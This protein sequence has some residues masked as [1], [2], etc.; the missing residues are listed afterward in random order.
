MTDRSK[1]RCCV[2][3]GAGSGLGRAMTLG[4][5][6]TGATVIAADVDEAG[7]DATVQQ[8]KTHPGRV[9]AHR[10]D[11]TQQSECKALIDKTVSSLGRIDVLV[12]CAGL[13]MAIFSREFLTKLVRFWEV[14]PDKWQRLYDVNVRAPFLLAHDAAPHMMRQGWGRIVNI[15]TSF[16]T[17]MREGN[18]PYGQAKAA[19]EASSA[20]WSQELEGTGV[21]C[22]VLLPG[23]A[24]DTPMIPEDAPVDRSKLVPAAAMVAPLLYL[25]SDRSDGVTGIRILAARWRADDSDEANLKQA[26][27]PIGWPLLGAE[28]GAPTR[29]SVA[30]R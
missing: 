13:N 28:S 5:A 29:G 16:S 30:S 26:G 1:A 7:L 15:T 14:D 23:G 25:A 21:T 2:V 3:T 6:Q 22:N 17:M 19:L 20:C 9:V 24:A 11:L 18:T 10:A 27:S 8:S 4:L 12:N